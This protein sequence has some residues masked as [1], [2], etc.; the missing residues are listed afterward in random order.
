ME[1]EM[2]TEAFRMHIVLPFGWGTH[3][4]VAAEQWIFFGEDTPEPRYTASCRLAIGHRPLP[5]PKKL[6]PQKGIFHKLLTYNIKKN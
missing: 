4:L 3:Q 6:I 1:T 2:K 5:L